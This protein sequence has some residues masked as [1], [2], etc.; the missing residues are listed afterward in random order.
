MM[1]YEQTNLLRKSG[2]EPMDAA[3]TGTPNTDVSAWP[4]L[5]QSPL[6]KVP[7]SEK[8]ENEPVAFASGTRSATVKY[9][10]LKIQLFLHN[11]L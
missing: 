1:M 3:R 11:Y 6:I 7:E 4:T 8:D 10:F 2:S 5:L 9:P